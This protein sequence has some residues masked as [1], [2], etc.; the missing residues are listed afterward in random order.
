MNV[1]L[2]ILVVEDNTDFRQLLTEALHLFNHEVTQA[3]SAEHAIEILKSQSFD[4]IFTDINMGEMNGIELTEYIRKTDSTIPI[5]I[6]T[7]NSDRQLIKDALNV[8][9]SDYLLKPIQIKDLPPIIDRNY[10]VN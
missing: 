8:G 3:E 7:G 2:S 10:N 5:I 4:F 9:V 1:S 6:L